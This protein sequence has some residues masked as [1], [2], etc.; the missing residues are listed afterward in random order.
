MML[1]ATS[2][3]PVSPTGVCTLGLERHILL[4]SRGTKCGTPAARAK[5][6]PRSGKQ[7]MQSLAA[8]PTLHPP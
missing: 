3:L 1:G 5:I 4:P 7:R 8:C 2:P 6:P